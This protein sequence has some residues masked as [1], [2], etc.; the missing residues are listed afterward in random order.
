MRFHV[1]EGFSTLRAAFV[2]AYKA[3]DKG[4][5]LDIATADLDALGK[6]EYRSLDALMGAAC[7]TPA[8]LAEK[9]RLMRER[10]PLAAAQLCWDLEEA[11]NRMQRDLFELQ[12]PCVSPA[13][14]DAFASWAETKR[15]YDAAC[16][17]GSGASQ[18]ALDNMAYRD[19][20]GFKALM[21]LPCYTP[22]DFVAKAYVELIDDV[23]PTVNGWAF[24][25]APHEDR[26]PDG[27][28]LD[29]HSAKAVRRDLAECDL[30][31][32]MIA[33]GRI[34]FDPGAW[35]AAA[36]R[37]GM[38]VM[39]AYQADGSRGLSQS[40]FRSEQ[41]HMCMRLLAFGASD[42]FDRAAL[43]GDYI[44]ERRPDLVLNARPIAEAAE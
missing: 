14:A 12:R 25:P 21:A 44:A 7:V 26:M 20:A 38:T 32:C 17:F 39:V 24:E 40:D 13:M 15:E 36:E 11:L 6:E 37:A 34:D 35:L 5:Y 42:G 8:E 28:G 9:I 43:V 30:G 33:L 2:D 1:T 3:Y 23:G 19:G 29:D 41:A 4:S 16:Q 10:G 18:D 31:C 27:L 22:G